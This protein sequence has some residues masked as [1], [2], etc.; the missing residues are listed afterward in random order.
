MPTRRLGVGVVQVPLLPEPNDARRPLEQPIRRLRSHQGNAPPVLRSV[1]PLEG[2]L[3]SGLLLLLCL[4]LRAGRG[5]SI[6]SV[7][8]AVSTVERG[9]R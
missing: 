6:R 3:Y 1:P 9:N 4:A 5:R 7:T 2:D 8:F